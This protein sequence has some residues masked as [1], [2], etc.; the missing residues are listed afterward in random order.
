MSLL[1]P[2]IN[3]RINSR[4]FLTHFSKYVKNDSWYMC[5]VGKKMHWS[6]L[7]YL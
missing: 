6:L 3:G 7:I 2:D 4:I 5:L 1:R